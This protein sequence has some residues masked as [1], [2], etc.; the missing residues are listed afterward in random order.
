[1]SNLRIGLRFSLGALFGLCA[2][3]GILQVRG[4]GLMPAF[5][6]NTSCA[7]FFL[8][9]GLSLFLT[10]KTQ[11]LKAIKRLRL[12]CAAVLSFSS[13][14]LFALLFAIL[15]SAS[16]AVLTG[17]TYVLVIVSAPVSCCTVLFWPIFA[18]ALLLVASHS[19]CRRMGAK[20]STN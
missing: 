1:M 2:A 11:D 17:L 7:L 19:L 5:W 4:L 10:W 8:L 9:A 20:N 6:E 3:D 13:L 12:W 14:L 15:G 18:W 16:P